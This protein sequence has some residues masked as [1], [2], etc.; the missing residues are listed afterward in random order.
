MNAPLTIGDILVRAGLA[1][2]RVPVRRMPPAPEPTYLTVQ[3]RHA[4]LNAR[5]GWSMASACSYDGCDCPGEHA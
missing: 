4:T 5:D 2:T 1:R 3:P